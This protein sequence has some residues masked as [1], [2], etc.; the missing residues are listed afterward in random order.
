[1]IKAI[2]IKALIGGFFTFGI[3][4]LLAFLYEMDLFY[5]QTFYVALG[6]HLIVTF[7][8]YS[9]STLVALIEVKTNIMIQAIVSCF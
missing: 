7:V 2:N 8:R 6:I 5:R 1:M 9:I 3:L 4:T